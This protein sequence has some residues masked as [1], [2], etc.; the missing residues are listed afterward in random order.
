MPN[1][2]EGTLKVRGS[3]ENVRNFVLN[4]LSETARIP[5][6]P[7]P[8]TKEPFLDIFDNTEDYFCAE[9]KKQCY[10][11]G[12]Y[13]GFVDDGW[14]EMS[15]EDECSIAL[16]DTRFAWALCS[17]DLL[18]ICK[19]YGVDMRITGYERGMEFVQEVE[20]VNGKII[21]DKEI[22][23]DDYQWECPCPLIGG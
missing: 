16:L 4:G 1:W 6:L 15:K 13:R 17:D 2:C 23:Y 3:F 21:L 9:I 22:H 8:E 7:L 19:K 14:I 12:T 5:G 20:I 18:K 10:I 11:N